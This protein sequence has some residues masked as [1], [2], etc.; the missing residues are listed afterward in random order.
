ML[1]ELSRLANRAFTGRRTMICTD[2]E[3][4]RWRIR[5]ALDV[6][7]WLRDWWLYGE[8]EI[9]HCRRM[10]EEETRGWGV[11]DGLDRALYDG[12]GFGLDCRRSG[13]AP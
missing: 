10:A 5:H 2:A 11:T 9:G 1:C 12:E 4:R 8:T 13:S 7:L 3:L 6:L